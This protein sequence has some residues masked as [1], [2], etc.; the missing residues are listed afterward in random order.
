MCPEETVDYLSYVVECPLCKQRV[1]LICD[2]HWADC[3]CPGPHAVDTPDSE[4]TEQ[5][6]KEVEVAREVQ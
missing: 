5:A 2:E 4:D 6:K 3:D 1:C